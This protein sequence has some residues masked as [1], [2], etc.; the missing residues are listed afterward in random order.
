ML[1]QTALTVMEYEM[2]QMFVDSVSTEQERGELQNTAESNARGSQCPS[3]LDGVGGLMLMLM[4][5]A[6]IKRFP[7]LVAR[8]F[9]QSPQL[10]TAALTQTRK[11]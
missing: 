3:E 5:P 8:L 6:V 9:L 2:S 10:L 7:F 11:C 1:F 4:T